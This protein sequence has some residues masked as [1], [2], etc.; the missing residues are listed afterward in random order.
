MN[1]R[2]FQR[3]VCSTPA[4]PITTTVL[5][6]TFLLPLRACL[7]TAATSS[8]T[9]TTRSTDPNPPPNAYLPHSPPPPPSS[10]IAPTPNT[11]SATTLSHPL[12]QPQLSRRTPF[13]H[14][15][16]PTTSEPDRD[17]LM[18]LATQK[19]HYITAHIHARPYL[20]TEGDT[21]RLPFLMPYATPGTILRLNCASVL[22]SRD[23]TFRG[24]GTSTSRG[25]NRGGIRAH[26]QVDGL[27]QQRPWIDEKYFICRAMVT[28]VEGEPMRVLLKT[29]RRQRKVK[30]VTTK[31]RF[32]ILRI[33]ELRVRPNG[34]ADG[35]GA[36]GEEVIEGFE[37]AG[38]EQLI[39]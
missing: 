33:M 39:V 32:T 31:G 28:A 30:R 19:P 37:P 16:P 15:P 20:L 27:T 26:G 17:L 18:A 5:P 23:F 22:G 1:T 9:T 10:P 11:T 25:G 36:M 29:K 7:A 2:A 38:L 34:L 6:P 24:N 21:L 13:T 8:T 3:L 35:E 12:R 14:I 4:K